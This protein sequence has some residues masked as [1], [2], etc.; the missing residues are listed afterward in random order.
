MIAPRGEKLCGNLAVV[1]ADDFSY[2]AELSFGYL[3]SERGNSAEEEAD[4]FVFDV[5]V[6]YSRYTNT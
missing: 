6:F 5:L 2:E 4:C 1:I 3:A